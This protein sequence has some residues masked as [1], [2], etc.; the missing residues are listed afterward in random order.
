MNT[1]AGGLPTAAPAAARGRLGRLLRRR[2]RGVAVMLGLTTVGS[3]AQLAGPA[4]I[5]RVIDAVTTSSDDARHIINQSVV[6]YIVCVVAAASLSYLAAIL[7]ARLAEDALNELRREVFNHTVALPIDIVERVGTGELVSR[8]TGDVQTLTDFTRRALPR[9]VFAGTEVALTVVALFVVDARL[10]AVAIVVAGPA[11]YLASRWYFHHAPHRYR[12]ERERTATLTGRI[13]ETYLGAM[14][15][16]LHRGTTRARQRVL[17]AGRDVVDAN[18][19]TTAARNRFR[20]YLQIAQGAALAAVLA[21]GT[22]LLGNDR[23][24]LGAVSAAAI[25]LTRVIDPVIVVL[26]QVDLLQR[27]TAALGRLV[28]VTQVPLAPDLP[29]STHERNPARPGADDPALE[30]EDVTFGYRPDH[31]VLH[32]I[33][34]RV[35]R[36]ER[37]AIVGASGAGKTTLTKLLTRSRYAETG[38]ILINRTPIEQYSAE[39]LARTVALVVQEPH[40]FARH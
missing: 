9:L 15:M 32:D 13:H 3:A 2:W 25:Y 30:L 40:T 5:G 11:S 1:A 16:R 34:L 33:T 39:Q 31:P 6:A 8:V 12:I 18:M 19:A 20:A 14:V 21:T 7:A 17:H 38:S 28:G 27:A 35:R 24:T 26:E 22:I 36:G 37:L 4:L 10:A 29:A 23:V